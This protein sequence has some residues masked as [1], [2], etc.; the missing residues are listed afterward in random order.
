M[1]KTMRTIHDYVRHDKTGRIGKLYTITR[2]GSTLHVYYRGSSVARVYD[3]DHTGS[4]K[5]CITTCGW[6]TLTT[7]NVINAALQ[8][9]FARYS[10][11]SV[12]EWRDWYIP[13]V[14]QKSHQLCI[15]S[16][17]WDGSPITYDSLGDT[18]GYCVPCASP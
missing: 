2:D 4:A 6:P 17:P 3:K 1:N 18:G 15:D 8:G 7:R 9:F 14:H 13:H 10:R 12:P 11:T 5:I 16:T